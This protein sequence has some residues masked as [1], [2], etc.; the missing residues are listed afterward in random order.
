MVIVDRLIKYVHFVPLKHRYTTTTVFKAFIE[1]I[2]W[3]C[4]AYQL[5]SL[6]TETR[7]SLVFSGRHCSN[8]REWLYKWVLATIHRLMN[9]L[10]LWITLWNYLCCFVGEQPTK[11]LDWLPWAK[12][13]YNTSTH[14]TIKVSPFEAVYGVPSPVELSYVPGTTTVHDVDEFLHDRAQILKD[15]HQNLIVAWDYMKTRAN[16][17]RRDVTF[18][19]GNYMYS[20]LQPYRQWSI[21]LHHSLKLSPRFYKPYWVLERIRTVTTASRSSNSWCLSC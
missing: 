16:R 3:S 20:K 1:K 15:L 19:I 10:K 8:R 7:S 11:W 14:T 17:N 21:M 12:Y 5:P 13:S 18:D 6:M 4:M 2:S 9:K